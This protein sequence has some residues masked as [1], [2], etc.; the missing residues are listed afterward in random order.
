MVGVVCLIM[1]ASCTSATPVPPTVT[2]TPPPTNTTTP[3]TTLT[4]TLTSTPT[5]TPSATPMSVP[6]PLGGAAKIA[7]AST[8]NG[9]YDIF[10]MKPDGSDLIQLTNLATDTVFP[11]FSPTG[12]F[13]LFFSFDVDVTPPILELWISSVDGTQQGSFGAGMLGWTSWSPDGM[14]LVMTG[15]WEEGN[16]DILSMNLDGTDFTWLTSEEEDDREPDWSLDGSTIAFTSYRDGQ[17]HI[18][19]MAQDG[20][21]QRRMATN[22][23]TEM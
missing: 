8:R 17:P 22:S 21:N 18:Y 12:D 23:M 11:E 2:A 14:K 6:T 15:F 5:A 4:P 19:L 16:L 7:F 13:F 3:L 20:T 10:I 1:I 9:K